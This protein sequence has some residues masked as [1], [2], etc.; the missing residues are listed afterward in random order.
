[1]RQPPWRNPREDY[2]MEYA[3]LTTDRRPF[4][5]HLEKMQ[6][7]SSFEHFSSSVCIL[8][9]DATVLDMKSLVATINNCDSDSCKVRVYDKDL[10]E[11]KSI[12]SFLNE[13]KKNNI[14]VI[15]DY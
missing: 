10:K 13:E 15:K 14:A 3:I 8:K 11:R 12:W 5:R 4:E 7:N 2:N 1:M 9:T 6:K